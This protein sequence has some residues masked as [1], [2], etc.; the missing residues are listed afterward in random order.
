MDD[1]IAVVVQI[2]LDYVIINTKDWLPSVPRGCSC[3]LISGSV[4][5]K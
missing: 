1:G 4:P 2:L 5:Q 3:H